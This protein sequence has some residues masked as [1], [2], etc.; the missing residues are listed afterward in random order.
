MW[1][2]ATVDNGKQSPIELRARWDTP[3]TITAGVEISMYT[4]SYTPCKMIGMMPELC[5]HTCREVED[6]LPFIRNF[7]TPGSQWPALFR[8]KPSKIC[9]SATSHRT[10]FRVWSTGHFTWTYRTHLSLLLSASDLSPSQWV[11]FSAVLPF[12][13]Y[14]IH[15]EQW[16]RQLTITLQMVVQEII[17]I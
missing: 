16:Q 5:L 2:A 6:G 7:W 11:H 1:L 9:P 17:H 12:L 10:P 4:I 14:K 8:K 3:K 13:Q 15:C